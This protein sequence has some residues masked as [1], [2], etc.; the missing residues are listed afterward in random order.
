MKISSTHDTN[1]NP[2]ALRL[3]TRETHNIRQPEEV[4]PSEDREP[5]AALNVNA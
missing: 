5:Y 3:E 4:F 2:N 1:D